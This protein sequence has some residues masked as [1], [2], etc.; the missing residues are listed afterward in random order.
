MT[1]GSG[2]G[3]RAL[4]Y[5]KSQLG[6]PYRYASAGPSSYDCSGLTSAAW[7]QVGVSL[8]RTSQSQIGVGRSVSEVRAAAG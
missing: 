7:S 3:A 1:D 4:A 8:P 5:A 2:K 6:K